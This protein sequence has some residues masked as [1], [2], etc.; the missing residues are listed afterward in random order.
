MSRSPLPRSIR[1]RLF[2]TVVVAV[3]LALAAMIGG[4]NLLLAHNLSRNA[5]QLVRARA[6]AEL[7][8]V[9]T[10]D[11]RVAIGE[12]AD[13]AAVDS[14]AWVFAGTRTL[15][16]P[17]TGTELAAI[18]HALAGRAPAK[19]D[20]GK[21]DTR[22][23]AVPIISGRRRLGTVVAAVGLAPYEQ[24]QQTALIASLALG[25]LLLIVVALAVRWLLVASLRPVERMTRQAA[26]W[27]ERDLGRRFGVGV[28]YDEVSELAATLDRLLERLAAG[29]RR[30][31]RFS[32]ELSHELR[33]PLARVIAQAEVALRQQR[34]PAH[35]RETLVNVLGNAQQVSRIVDALVAAARQDS[36]VTRGTADAQA[37]C[38]QALEA[39]G[40]LARKR[41]L[42]LV[43]VPPAQ[44]LRLGLDADLAERILQPVVE[45][46]CRYGRSRVRIRLE[47]DSARIAY[48]VED[49]GPGVSPDEREAIFEPGVRGLAGRASNGA[50]GAGL[51]LALARRLARS[52]SGEIAVEAD[53][54]GGRFLVS[55]PAA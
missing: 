20:V 34:R 48:L 26:E 33:T 3:G 32:A 51:G 54:G 49:D 17:R 40:D 30:E 16:A 18:A 22:L 19:T 21:S 8:L 10:H 35:Y 55:L 43:N 42:E 11:G 25:G 36:A 39:V 44:P 1:G 38:E 46:A 2:V 53:P 52:A 13:D 47:R 31:Q 27:S 23:Y 6:A 45:N 4:F 9:R 37:V 5:D 50:G 12:T 7:G 14:S 29:L 41:Q 28:P 15:E 24:T